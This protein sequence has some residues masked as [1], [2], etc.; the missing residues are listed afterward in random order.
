MITLIILLV[1]LNTNGTISIPWFIFLSA[2]I[3]VIVSIIEKIVKQD[4]FR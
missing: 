4:E 3:E 1:Y 2:G